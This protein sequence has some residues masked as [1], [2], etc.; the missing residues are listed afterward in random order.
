MELIAGDGVSGSV[1]RN[2]VAVTAWQRGSQARRIAERE[3]RVVAL[4]AQ[5]RVTL[6]HRL[7]RM[8]GCREDAEDVLQEACLKL[9]RVDDLWAPEHFARAFFIKI[10]TNLARDALRR[11][12]SHCSD[13]HVDYGA[14]DLVHPE[15]Q[16]DEQLD[17]DLARER[18]A[19]VMQSLSQR[20]Q[21]VLMLHLG[22]TLSYRAIAVRL[23]VSTKTVERDM[24]VVKSF[25]LTSCQ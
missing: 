18:V 5:L 22:E 11:R 20:H 4:V 24:A 9:L 6:L 15:P 21:H 23:G 8:L 12:K 1:Y 19:R 14:L 17:H 16:P 25:L 3:R 2:S 13:A 10:T 7:T